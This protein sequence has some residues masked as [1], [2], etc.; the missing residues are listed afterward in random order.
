MYS[1]EAHS[2][3]SSASW[4]IS[5]SASSRTCQIN[6]I[7]KKI[8]YSIVTKIRYTGGGFT[9]L[10]S[11][12]TLETYGSAFFRNLYILFIYLFISCSYKKNAP[13]FDRLFRSDE[14]C[15]VKRLEP[16]EPD[17]SEKGTICLTF[18]MLDL[19]DC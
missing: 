8:N 9:F 2:K 4:S 6:P 14:A 15:D 3:W 7:E 13:A 5:S 18:Q 19:C 16:V 10:R 1:G 11:P 17:S 12:R